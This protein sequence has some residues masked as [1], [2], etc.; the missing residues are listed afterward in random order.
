[1][2]RVA[3]VLMAL[4]T[5]S[6]A[7]SQTQ[8][9]FTAFPPDR[10][11]N[12]LMGAHAWRIYASGLIDED[13][14]KRLEEVIQRN[15]I[16]QHSDIFLHSGGGSLAGGMKL[17]KVIRKYLL[18]SQCRSIRPFLEGPRQSESRELLQCVRNGLSGR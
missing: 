2:L 7:F 4:F 14:D 6:K 15:N 13:A 5:A 1:M 12:A 3:V 9:Q 11:T 18:H 17:G 16:P 10:S 8:M